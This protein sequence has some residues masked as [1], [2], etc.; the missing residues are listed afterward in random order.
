VCG[1]P[2]RRNNVIHAA[3]RKPVVADER[4]DQRRPQTRP[5]ERRCALP[6]GKGHCLRVL[7]MATASV[8]ATRRMSFDARARIGG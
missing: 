4:N 1:G 7:G 5:R 2:P 8:V 6:E 3:P